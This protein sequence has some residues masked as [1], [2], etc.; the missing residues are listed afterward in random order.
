MSSTETR[1]NLQFFQRILTNH[2]ADILEDRYESGASVLLE[3]PIAPK[4]EARGLFVRSLNRNDLMFRT[5]LAYK[6]EKNWR[7]LMGVDIFRGPLLGVFG[8]YERADRVYS[9]VR[10]SF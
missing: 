1:L 2:G 10:Y 7:L 8:R 6:F 3:G 4:W 5:W 9:E